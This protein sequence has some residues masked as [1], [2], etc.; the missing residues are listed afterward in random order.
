ISED[1]LYLNIF[2]S[3]PSNTG[4]MSVLVFIHGGGYTSGSG[5]RWHGQILA[6]HEDIVVI[7]INYRLGVLGFM[8]SAIQANL[9]L[10]DQSLA[11]QWVKDNIENFGGNPQHIT[12]AGNSAGASSAM[13][14]MVMPSSKGLFRGAIFQSGP[15][16]AIPSFIKSRTSLPITLKDA[17]ISFKRFSSAANCTKS[18]ASETVNCLQVLTIQQLVNLQYSLQSNYPALISPFADGSN[19][20]E[21]LYTAIPAGRFHKANVMM[22][23]TLNDGYFGL[24]LLPNSVNVAKGISRQDFMSITSNAF[25]FA[26]QGVKLSIQYQYT[27]WSNFNSPI[28]NRDQY[29]EIINDFIFALPNE[30]YADQFSRYIP[31]YSYIFAHRTSGTFRP[32]YLKVVHSMEM[33]YAFSYAIDRPADYSTTFNAEEKDLCKYIMSYWGSFIRNGLVPM[34]EFYN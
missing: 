18:T 21:V 11:L 20:Q 12:I 32:T 23:T 28:S 1:C 2:T 10:L 31:T 22:G 15:Y 33:P 3:N 6:A 26:N 27:N 30:Y 34:L 19:V 4:N 25:P 17:E 5:A 13:Y 14:H 8:S 29:G 9:G 16:G 7:T 24:I